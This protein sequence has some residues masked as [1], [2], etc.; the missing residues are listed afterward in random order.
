VALTVDISTG[1]SGT[2]TIEDDGTPANGTSIV[3]RP[4]GSLFQVVVHPADQLTFVSRAGQSVVVNITDSLGAA[5][6]T[7]GSLVT[8]SANPDNILVDRVSTTGRVALRA[9]QAISEVGSEPGADIIAATL[10]MKAGTGIGALN[11]IEIVASI[12][13]AES[14][15][16]G[17]NLGNFGNLTI[18]GGGANGLRGLFTGTSG[19][20]TLAN[21]GGVTFADGEGTATV[22]SAG[23]VM[24]SSFDLSGGITTIVDRAAILAGGS[25]VL[26]ARG[27]IDFGN[28]TGFD[29]DVRAGGNVSIS[30][31]GIFTLNGLSDI[32]SDDRGQN[33]GGSVSIDAGAGIVILNSYAGSTASVTAGGNSG[34]SVTLSSGVGGSVTIFGNGPR[35][36]FSNSGSVTIRADDLSISPGSG[37]T[38]NGGNL[39]TIATASFGREIVLGESSG[40]SPSVYLGDDE[41]DRVFAQNIRIGG[42]ETGLLQVAGAI[43]ASA[44][45]LTLQAGGDLVVASNLTAGANLVLIAGDSLQQTAGTTI[46]ATNL[47][48]T[49]DTP[50]FDPAGGVLTFGG[51][52]AATTNTL[53]GNGDNDVLSGNG[54]ANTL[55][56]LGG[57]DILDG[58]GGNDITNGGPGDDTHVV[59]SDADV[60]FEAVTEGNDR[61]LALA[62][63]ALPAG[64][65]IELL[66]SANQAAVTPM[67]LTGNDLKQ[68]I[69]GNDG[70]N[71]L[72]GLDGSDTLFGNGGNDVLDGGLG[73]DVTVGGAGNDYYFVDSVNDAVLEAVGGGS[74]E[75]DTSVSYRLGGTAEVELLAAVDSTSTVALDIAGNDFGQVIFGNAGANVL[76]GLG[77]VDSLF[78]GSGN[79]FLN[80]GS[81]DDFMTGA[82]GDDAY[83]VD[84]AADFIDEIAGSGFDRVLASAS[85]T[86]AASVSIELLSAA[87]QNGSEALTLIGN[88]F[89]NNIQANEGDNILIG[90]AGNDTL[91]GL[92]GVDVL[93]G[94]LDA[95]TLIGGAGGDS[96]IFS[97]MLSA[98]NIDMIMGFASG[99][100]H[101]FLD[102]AVFSALATGALPAGAFR[103][104]TAAAD[105][106]DRIIYDPASG[107]LFYDPD[108]NGSAASQIQFAVLQGAP[109]LAATDFVVI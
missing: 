89:A 108:G 61:V 87:N 86:L 56:G 46:T 13:E 29:N 32:A 69:I 14:D 78:G 35:S 18:G 99:S 101:I 11:A 80:G 77:G 82:A 39:V 42:P 74:D 109:P 104:G 20:I 7:I 21:L 71:Y 23:N 105:A 16:G 5:N 94:G 17:I 68:I 44:G 96:L 47:T 60:V 51:T 97:T 93:N 40:P 100:D 19:N 22:N 83:F 102:D 25:V 52:L 1:P 58:R 30:V 33:T 64:T 70:A 106:D 62:S 34:G 8:P 91:F 6:F 76:E 43:S 88:G 27:D 45:I 28:S 10:L 36:V 4:D 12:L 37:I 65:E 81:G 95:D 73:N 92:G 63:Y 24:I 72:R 107:A 41:L 85:Y 84:S 53:T 3:R 55:F 98:A 26:A 54:A 15:T 48:A 103:T 9:N 50:D 57:N 66:A 90:G 67:D 75:V 49:V 31:G 59:D 79:D 2:W 38:V